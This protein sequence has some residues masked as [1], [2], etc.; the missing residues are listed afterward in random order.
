MPMPISPIERMPTVGLGGSVEADILR[1]PRAMA[2]CFSRLMQR[3]ARRDTCINGES[4]G[5]RSTS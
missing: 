4:A 2:W 3:R 5:I 1:S